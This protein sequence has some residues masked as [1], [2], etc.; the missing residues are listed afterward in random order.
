MAGPW[1]GVA[2]LALPVCRRRMDRPRPWGQS[3]LRVELS[4]GMN[5][6]PFLAVRASA[7]ISH[8]IAQACQDSLNSPVQ[9]LVRMRTPAGEEEIEILRVQYI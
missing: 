9:C 7:G 6:M 4:K 8:N 3:M 1:Q 5:M 2:Q